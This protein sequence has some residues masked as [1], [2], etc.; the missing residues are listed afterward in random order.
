MLTSHGNGKNACAPSPVCPPSS[1]HYCFSP[2]FFPH[3]RDGLAGL[4]S[5]TFAENLTLP[6]QIILPQTPLTA[7]STPKRSGAHS[8]LS[9]TLTRM[10]CL[11]M[12]H[13][14]HSKD[15]IAQGATLVKG[16]APHL[17]S[18]LALPHPL[19]H[20]RQPQIRNVQKLDNLHPHAAPRHG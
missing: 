4:A 13:G 8:R 15:L 20:P 3:V 12:D 11:Q 6:P 5:A 2:T 10:M 7:R 9:N 16:L 1:P 19:S 14:R 18:A 17:Q